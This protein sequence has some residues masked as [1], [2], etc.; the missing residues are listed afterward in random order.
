MKQKVISSYF[1]GYP[2]KLVSEVKHF[3]HTYRVRV[4]LNTTQKIDYVQKK[5]H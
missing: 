5:Y 3:F 2:F 1:L 4:D